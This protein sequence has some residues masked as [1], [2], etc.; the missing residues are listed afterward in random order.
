M[1]YKIIECN[2]GSDEWKLARK[3]KVTAS[4]ASKIITP[5]GKLSASADSAI[6]KL[7]RE[8][9]MDDPH[10]FFG[11][12]HTEWGHTHEPIARNAFRDATGLDVIE[13]GFCESIAHPVL[14]CSP[15]GLIRRDGEIVAGLEIKCPCVDKH[16]E[17]LLSGELPK[18]YAPQVH[19]S[20]AVTGLPAWYFISY[21][22]SLNPLIIRVERSDYTEKLAQA[23]I[24][25][26]ER[27]AKE[28]PEIW[29]KIL[30]NAE[31]I[32]PESKP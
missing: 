4:M 17:Y 28:A 16:V 18:E 9:V 5:T 27:Y 25:F 10:E 29:G 15:D 13:A 3:G 20:L 7:A 1:K 21:F 32:H 30:P 12:A 11:N 2:Q 19:W 26:A 31:S 23:A 22:P 14:G 8:C 6:R 24:E